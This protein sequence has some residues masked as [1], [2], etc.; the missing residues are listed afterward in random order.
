M[1]S[2][3]IGV[4]VKRY[5]ACVVLSIIMPD[6]VPKRKMKDNLKLSRMGG[7]IKVDRHSGSWEPELHSILTGGENSGV[8]YKS[9]FRR[10]MISYCIKNGGGSR[11]AIHWCT[12]FVYGQPVSQHGS[13]FCAFIICEDYHFY[14]IW[15]SIQLRRIFF[16]ALLAITNSFQGDGYG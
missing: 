13:K 11:P 1:I 6:N 12:L 2:C 7:T 10:E 8:Y 16:S 5:D 9:N 4:R 15:W 14:E 3:L